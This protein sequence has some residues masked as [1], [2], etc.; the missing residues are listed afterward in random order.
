VNIQSHS[1][2]RTADRR[3][4]FECVALVLQGGGALLVTR[5]E[6]LADHLGKQPETIAYTGACRAITNRIP[7]SRA[8]V[9]SGLA[10]SGLA[11][12]VD[13]GAAMISIWYQSM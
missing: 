8:S 9:L 7:Q 13:A 2:F 10:A 6:G 1:D 11:A 12:A 3:L 4:P 5:T